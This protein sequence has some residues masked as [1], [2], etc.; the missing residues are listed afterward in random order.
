MKNYVLK[1]YVTEWNDKN[2]WVNLRA[3]QSKPLDGNIK[4]GYVQNSKVYPVHMTVI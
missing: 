3:K 1:I 4:K 2:I